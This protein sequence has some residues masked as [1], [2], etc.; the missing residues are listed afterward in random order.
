[1]DSIDNI[2]T[3][4]VTFYS[5]YV[6]FEIGKFEESIT[7]F[8]SKTVQYCHRGFAPQTFN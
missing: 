3:T 7:N 4:V 8:E 5:P 2:A 6:Y 1:M